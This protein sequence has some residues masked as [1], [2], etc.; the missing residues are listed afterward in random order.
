VI[1]DATPAQKIVRAFI[2]VVVTVAVA[3]AAYYAI[4]YLAGRAHR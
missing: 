1:E 2:A 3:V 4:G